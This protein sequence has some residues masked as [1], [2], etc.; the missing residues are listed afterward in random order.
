ML[1][2][3][4]KDGTADVYDDAYDIVIHCKGEED[5]KDAILALKNAR[6]WIPV[7]ERL[8]ESGD[9]EVLVQ[10]NGKD[11]AIKLI[12]AFM[13]ASY[14]EEIGW[15]SMG[16]PDLFATVSAWMP[17]PEMYKEN[18][19]ECDLSCAGPRESDFG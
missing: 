2:M 11:G 14:D 15:Y 1:V 5:Q 16:H 4:D 7:T 17:L 13:I 8:P 10:C 3:I 12:D 9:E 18:E 19:N 6:R